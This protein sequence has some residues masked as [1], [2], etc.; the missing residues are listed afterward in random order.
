[1]KCHPSPIGAEAEAVRKP[2]IGSRELPGIRSIEIHAED[3]TNLVAHYLY[4][5][6]VIVEQQLRRV[7]H[8]HTVQRGDFFESARIKIVNPQMGR[9]QGVVLIEG[10]ARTVATVFHAQE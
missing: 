10:P 5:H 9:S 3:L 7:K 1:M 4:Q 2:L 6:T 8:R